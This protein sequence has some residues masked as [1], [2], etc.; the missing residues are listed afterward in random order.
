[1]YLGNLV[2]L[3]G[4]E[5]V[6]RNPLHPY[7][8]TLISA[9]PTTEKKNTER[10]ILKGDIPSNIFPPSGCKFRTRC[11][12]ATEK[13]ARSVPEYREVEPGRFVACHHYEQT[14]EMK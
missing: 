10:I 1:M 6:Y 2:E 7:T 9:I 13:C 12:L 11:P 3:G 14:K 8:K 5:E 4:A